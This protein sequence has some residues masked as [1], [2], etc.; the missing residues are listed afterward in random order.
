MELYTAIIAGVSLFIGHWIQA[1]LTRR[2]DR[3]RYNQELYHQVISA[4]SKFLDSNEEV[5]RRH[6]LRRLRR[7]WLYAPNKV[8]E[9]GERFREC[10]TKSMSSSSETQELFWNLVKAMRKDCYHRL[11]A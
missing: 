3:Q 6:C 2:R 10:L 4:Y 8:V 11:A 5:E 9:I 7:L 1:Y